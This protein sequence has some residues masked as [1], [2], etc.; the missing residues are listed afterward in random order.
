VTATVDRCRD[1]AKAEISSHAS[2]CGGKWVS[3]L[4]TL[5]V[6]LIGVAGTTVA[7]GAG[8]QEKTAVVKAKVESVETV[9]K[10]V[11]DD[12]SVLKADMAVVKERTK[13]ILDRLNEIHQTRR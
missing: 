4:V 6:A 13:Q 12:V 11:V 10:Q 7:W 2:T 8:Q 5:S 9:Q 3:W 1:I